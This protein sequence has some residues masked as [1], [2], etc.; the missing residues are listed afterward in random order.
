MDESTLICTHKPVHLWS[1]ASSKNFSE[2]HDEAV[3]EAY[4]SKITDRARIRFLP[5]KVDISLVEKV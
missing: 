1:K 2:K 5:Q 4:G 3:D